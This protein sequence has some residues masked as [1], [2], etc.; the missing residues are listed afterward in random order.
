MWLS[1]IT[2][3]T[4]WDTNQKCMNVLSFW[5]LTEKQTWKKSKAL[6]SD[7]AKEFLKLDDLLRKEGIVH[8]LSFPH[9][10]PQNG[11]VEC[12]QRH[13][14][15]MGITMLN[16]TRMPTEYWDY[17]FMVVVF[18]DNNNPTHIL[19]N[20]LL[21]KA[22]SGRIP[23]YDKLRIFGSKCFLTLGLIGITSS[24]SSHHQVYLGATQA[25]VMGIYALIA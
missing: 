10:H 11:K 21:T 20:R 14:V 15:D 8:R 12:R 24:N 16:H 7:N 3:C 4:H 6:Q 2:K 1:I 18:L 13:I 25:L 22:L 9:T 17:I 23:E 19:N 5:A